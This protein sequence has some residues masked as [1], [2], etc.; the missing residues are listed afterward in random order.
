[1]ASLHVVIILRTQGEYIKQVFDVGQFGNENEK[2]L[3]SR[4]REKYLVD[5]LSKQLANDITVKG[6]DGEKHKRRL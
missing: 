1:M 4:S 6:F 5:N 2:N 3:S